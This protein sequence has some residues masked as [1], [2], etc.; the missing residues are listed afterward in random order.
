MKTPDVAL[1]KEVAEA[2]TNCTEPMSDFEFFSHL[3][4][5]ESKD[6][7]GKGCHDPQFLRQA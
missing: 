3:K 7:T 1:L 4:K 2:C 5:R 6:C